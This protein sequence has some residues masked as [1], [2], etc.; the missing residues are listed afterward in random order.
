MSLLSS[1]Q[2]VPHLAC[3][4]G[5]ETGLFMLDSLSKVC[6]IVPVYLILQL[7]T[8]SQL[9]EPSALCSGKAKVLDVLDT[10]RAELGWGMG[11]QG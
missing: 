10:I 9:C 3:I 4:L 1:V 6:S 11:G 5:V 7:R 8:Q 2:S